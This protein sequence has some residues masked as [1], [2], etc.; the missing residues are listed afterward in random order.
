MAHRHFHPEEL[1]EYDSTV[2][3]SQL[4]YVIFNPAQLLPLFVLHIATGTGS[5]WTS[6]LPEA[7]LPS[8]PR[9]RRFAEDDM[10]S[11]RSEK[12]RQRKLTAAARKH[13][14]QGFGPRGGNFVVEDI[15]PV[16]DDEELWGEYQ[17][18]DTWREFGDEFQTERRKYSSKG[19]SEA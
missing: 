5:E 4:E 10:A 8:E 11:A 15:A 19:E 12:E 17:S 14:P 9:N 18:P 13:L 16:D 3:P 1:P 7:M 2:S 6:N